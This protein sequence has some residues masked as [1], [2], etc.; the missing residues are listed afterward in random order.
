MNVP[1]ALGR[2]LV[3]LALLVV[4]VALVGCG[5]STGG[6][7]DCDPN[8]C[9]FA[10][11]PDSVCRDGSDELIV[12]NNTSPSCVEGECSFDFTIET[13]EFGC[14]EGACI[15]ACDAISCVT[16]PN[17]PICDG[18]VRVGPQVPGLCV[19]DGECTYPTLRQDC[20]EQ[21]CFGGECVDADCGFV[22][23][24]EPPSDVCE[25]SIAV[26]YP[27]L[28]TCEEATVECTYAAVRTD[29]AERGDACV[30]GACAPLCDGVVCNTPPV[31]FCDGTTSV[32][33]A[34]VGVCSGGVCDYEE[35]RQDCT[36]LGLEC[37]DGLCGQACEDS[38]C[39]NPPNDTCSDDNTEAIFYERQGACDETDECSYVESGRV[40]CAEL[41]QVCV[42][43]ACVPDPLCDGVSCEV[44]PPATCEADVAVEFLA[45]DCALG[46]CNYGRIETNCALA[47]QVCESGSCENFCDIAVC[48]EPPDSFC[49]GDT[50]FFYPVI[51]ECSD[52]DGCSYDPLPVDC[53]ARGEICFDGACVADECFDALC[54]AP[55]ETTECLGDV[56]YGPQPIGYCADGACTYDTVPVED[57]AALGL[58]CVLGACAEPCPIDICLPPEPTC[59]DDD[60]LV[61]YTGLGVCEG[62]VTCDYESVALRT[63][64]SAEGLACIDGE[65][66]DA[67]DTLICDMPAEDFCDGDVLV[68]SNFPSACVDSECTYQTT[69]IDCSSA[70]FV[71]FEGACVD[72]CVG[73]ICDAPPA[74]GCED[75]V[76][77]DYRDIG[78][79][80]LGECMYGSDDF[81]CSILEWD[82]VDAECV[83]PCIGVVCDAPPADTC[84]ENI[85]LTYTDD[86]GVCFGG[87]CTY[88]GG[89]EDCELIGRVCED[90]ACVDVCGGVVCETPPASFCEDDVV[91]S[92]AASGDCVLG[93]CEYDEVRTDCSVTGGFCNA[94]A[95]FDACVGVDCPEI[96]DPV[97]E[98][99]VRVQYAAGDGTCLGGVCAYDT[100]EEDCLIAG[101][102]C[103]AGGCVVPA[104]LCADLT[105]P[106]RE[107]FCVGDTLV[108]TSAPGVCD[109]AFPGCDYR[110]VEVQA[111][112]VGD[113][114]CF[115]GACVRGPLVGELVLSEVFYDA[116]GTD[117]GKEWVE[118]VN[119]STD[120]LS[121]GGVELISASGLVVRLPD[122]SIEPGGTYLAAATLAPVGSADFRYDDLFF[123]LPDNGGRVEIRWNNIPVDSVTIDEAAGWPN[124]PNQAL[125]LDERNLSASANN[126]SS[127]WCVATE[128]YDGASGATGT[129]GAANGICP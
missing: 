66:V 107:P 73:V 27:A 21:I 129:P 37:I 4:S 125:R 93:L 96:L 82:C 5:D 51:G 91:V 90:A 40:N 67:C 55:P 69:R 53:G 116:S 18:N 6:V 78:E 23:C 100:L 22:T 29:C 63:D 75:N 46:A 112:C 80:V 89:Q 68:A 58:E 97:C 17:P 26:Q 119:V 70:G 56:V 43:A 19:G 15:E 9:L 1:S 79:C 117:V 99:D 77:R 13:C 39:V 72:A 121:L 88:F 32:A 127:A 34:A 61:E 98:G 84:D 94:G 105:C 50:A 25:G 49:E 36:S 110:A 42:N 62:G 3:A 85:A 71:C 124:A 114:S 113:A 108:T 52:I 48:N 65:C 81:D 102:R 106:V 109:N 115:E 118:F 120:E 30:D 10:G 74:D 8:D 60:T 126:A 122:D 57:C 104:D 111:P 86:D 11:P 41:G 16:P 83:D 64:C 33:F 2:N 59:E 128:V 7:N 123:N 28:G 54:T 14:S 24:N 87:E 44:P 12:F 95:C 101:E 45:G 103:V 38:T 31:N 20:G 76:A 92:Y 35:T 47:G